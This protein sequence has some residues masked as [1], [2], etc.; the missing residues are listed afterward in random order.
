MLANWRAFVFVSTLVKMTACET[1]VTCI[2]QVKIPLP[3]L[4][5]KL[6]RQRRKEHIRSSHATNEKKPENLTLM[7]IVTDEVERNP[8]ENT[9]TIPDN[10]GIDLFIASGVTSSPAETFP[11]SHSYTAEKEKESSDNFRC[12]RYDL[13]RTF[14]ECSEESP[15][16]FL[17]WEIK[18]GGLWG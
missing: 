2:A 6:R 15:R 1:N 5:C 4:A 12:D 13:R 14:G 8:R 16:S 10:R 18:D 17:L 11:S 9:E 3:F 7:G